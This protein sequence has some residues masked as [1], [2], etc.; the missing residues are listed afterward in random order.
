MM[1]NTCV[2][3]VEEKRIARTIQALQKNQ[4]EAEYLPTVQQT[5]ERVK[6]LLEMGA[7]VAT[8]GSMTLKECGIIDLLRSGDYQY[9][10]REKATDPQQTQQLYRQAFFADYYLTSSNAITETGLLYNVDGNS[11]R[12]AA[13][14]FG[15]KKVLVIAGYNKIVPDQQHAIERVRCLAAPA[16]AI[17][18]QCKTPCAVQGT[19]CDCASDDRVCRS[20]V[21][22]GRQKAGGR[23]HVLL[24][25]ESLGF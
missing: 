13:M 15:P 23:V 25:G 24:V 11:N 4:F 5:L 10:D 16:N 18:L 21:F 6:Q 17:R 20:Y 1:Q 3:T 9:L 7:V 14:L 12:V 22:M 2:M 19:C 8:G